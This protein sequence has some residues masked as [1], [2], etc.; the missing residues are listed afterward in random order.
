[1]SFSI[2]SVCTGNVCRSPVAELLLADAL[3]SIANVHVESAGTGALVGSGVP[4]Q[5]QRL[6]AARGVDASKHSARQID[7]TMI[8]HA[9]LL[10]AMSREHRRIVVESVPAAMRRSFT[11]RELARIADVLEPQLPHIISDAGA[12]SAEEGMRAAV[13]RAAALR[14]TI[15]PPARPEE[16]DIV[17]PYRR[18]DETYARSF[19]ELSPAAD[20]VA[21]FL[22][23]AATLASA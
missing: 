13:A 14:G 23:S 21:R 5:A 9:D 3:S 2:L 19:A 7:A 16:F 22:S 8:R 4:E 1:V 6:A 12:T 20:T 11:L 10:V 15:E 17:D 18:S